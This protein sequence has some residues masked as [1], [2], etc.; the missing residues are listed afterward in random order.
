MSGSDHYIGAT[1]AAYLA[2]HGH[3]SLAMVT[4]DEPVFAQT[5]RDRLNGFRDEAL[6]AQARDVAANSEVVI[7]MLGLPA[8][9]ESEGFDRTTLAMPANQLALLDAI[10]AVN[11]RVI[12]VLSNGAV[13][14]MASWKNKPAAIIETWLL[15]ENS[16][17]ATRDLLF[18]DVTPSGRLAETI[19]NRLEDIPANLFFPGENGVTR[20]GEGLYV[21]YRYF[22]SVGA[23]VCYP[24]G[25]GLSYGHTTIGDVC[26]D[27]GTPGHF[28][29]TAT[30]T[31]DSDVASSEVVQVYVR[32]ETGGVKRPRHELKGFAKVYLAPGESQ[33][34]EIVLDQ[35]AFAYWQVQLHD[36]KVEGGT[37]VIE[38]GRSSRDIVAEVG[39]DLADDG[40]RPP[41]NEFS[42]LQEWLDDPTGAPIMEALM[43]RTGMVMPDSVALRAM[44]MQSPAK[45]VAMLPGS[46]T[47]V[48]LNEALAQWAAA[49]GR[50]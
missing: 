44:W 17:L 25:Y 42:T 46:M 13:V 1:Q 5:A 4:V 6:L 37:Y 38:V 11:P 21:G 19:P 16:G 45:N 8:Y 7:A 34:V 50:H 36:W 3:R 12:V 2:E 49:R 33:T 43:E 24:F 23:D 28:T 18:G 30:V 9:H 29:V 15:G 14:E 47:R 22:D 40:K 48:D 20:Y 27:E 41:L 10:V 32:P 26:V 39:V 35:R 31:N